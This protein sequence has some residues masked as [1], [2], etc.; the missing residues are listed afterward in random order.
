MDA[1]GLVD[2]IIGDLK[3]LRRSRG[4]D[5]KEISERIRPALRLACGITAEDGPATIRAKLR[6]R[7]RELAEHLPADLKVLAQAALA[8]VPEASDQFYRARLDWAA[9]QIDR[10]ER[11]L[12]RRADEALKQLAEL[13]AAELTALPDRQD[14]DPAGDGWHTEMLRAML[15]LSTAEPEA[16]EFRTIVADRDELPEIDLAVTLTAAPN[17]SSS[18]PGALAMDVLYGGRLTQRFMA[19][20]RRFAMKLT[21]PEPLKAG[22][23]HDFALRF[24]VPDGGTMRPHFVSVTKQPCDKV[25]LRVKFDEKHVPPNVWM[26]DRA[27]QSDLVDPTQ[28]GAPV[29]V[30]GAGELRVQFLAPAPGFAYGVRWEVDENTDSARMR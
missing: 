9:N 7:L 2:E 16:Y 30:D 14:G 23:R 28:H 12:R 25:E 22:A 20:E 15:N 3:V 17:G 27:F 4:V 6:V 19:A 8:L 13:A 29:R 24:R 26:L 21:F 5:T 18:P 10:Q 1:H 11:T